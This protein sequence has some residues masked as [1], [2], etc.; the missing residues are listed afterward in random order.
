MVAKVYTTEPGLAVR[1]GHYGE[2]TNDVPC[3][4]P[5]EVAQELEAEMRGADPDPSQVG[6][7]GRAAHRR[8]R[9]ERE[10]APVATTMSRKKAPAAPEKES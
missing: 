9:I 2:A 7:V 8:Y 5:E 1:I 10:D 3:M 6:N 4:V